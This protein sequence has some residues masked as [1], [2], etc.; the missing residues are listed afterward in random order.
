MNSLQALVPLFIGSLSAVIAIFFGCRYWRLVSSS[1]KVP[2]ITLEPDSQIGAEGDLMYRTRFLYHVDGERYIGL[3]SA[4]SNVAWL[5][6]SGRT[7]LVYYDPNK[8]DRGKLIGAA[9][10]ALW[11][12]PIILLVYLVTFCV[13]RK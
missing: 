10:L 9:E 4:T 5:H 1:T 12:T 13:L 11:I 6:R 8:P 2:G 3:G 7:V